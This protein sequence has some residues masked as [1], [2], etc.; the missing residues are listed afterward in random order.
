M[1]YDE[2]DTKEQRSDMI[3]FADVYNR[4]LKLAQNFNNIFKSKFTL[5]VDKRFWEFSRD[6]L[7]QCLKR[8]QTY[9]SVRF[10]YPIY[11]KKLINDQEIQEEFLKIKLATNATFCFINDIDSNAATAYKIATFLAQLRAK[12]VSVGA[13]EF[14]AITLNHFKLEKAQEDIERCF[15]IITTGKRYGVRFEIATPNAKTPYLNLLQM[16]SD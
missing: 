8:L 10:F 4:P 2:K 5:V 14:S 15:D 7:I 13:V 16:L 6:F 3:Q 1:L 12:T 11:L 9:P